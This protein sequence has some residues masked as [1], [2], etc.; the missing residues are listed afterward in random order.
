MNGGA[1]RGD[2]LP[3][4]SRGWSPGMRLFGGGVGATTTT[5]EDPAE[6][7]TFS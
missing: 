2:G 3:I 4:T 6:T 5:P 1:D 7:E